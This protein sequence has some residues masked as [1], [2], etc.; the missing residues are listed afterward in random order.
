MYGDS[1]GFRDNT[2]YVHHRKRGL[3]APVKCD[4]D[5][6]SSNAL[7]TY[8]WCGEHVNRMRKGR[9]F[10]DSHSPTLLADPAQ[11]RAE[12]ELRKEL[13]PTYRDMLEDL[14]TVVSV[15]APDTVVDPEVVAEMVRL[16]WRRLYEAPDGPRCP[17]CGSVL[18]TILVRGNERCRDCGYVVKLGHGHGR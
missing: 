14:A 15:L 3:P 4:V 5:G 12:A 6:C 9:P 11:A 1:M 18:R 10:Q 8:P 7:P 13:R 16:G 2:H 17:T